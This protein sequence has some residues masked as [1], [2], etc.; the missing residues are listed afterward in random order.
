MWW[1]IRVGKS[2]MHWFPLQKDFNKPKFLFNIVALHDG[3]TVK[4]K[5]NEHYTNSYFEERL[6][7]LANTIE[8]FPQH[9][10]G[11]FR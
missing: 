5:Q 8:K 4:R 2:N 11:T 6:K 9:F 10:Q 1:H 7:Y 3:S